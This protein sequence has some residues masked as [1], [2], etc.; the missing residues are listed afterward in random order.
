MEKN[1]RSES[2]LIRSENWSPRGITT[3]RNADNF[4][5]GI[6]YPDI[7]I[8]DTA[9]SIRVVIEIKRAV[10]PHSSPAVSP[11][12]WNEKIDLSFET[13]LDQ[14]ENQIRNR[15][16]TSSSSSSGVQFETNIAYA[17]AFCDK[18]C[19]IRKVEH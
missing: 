19:R 16:Y 15:R 1:R 10:P 7:T 11:E 8:E 13:A 2:G 3:S 6:G 17:A 9:R 14:A 4:E 5:S 18:E 12:K